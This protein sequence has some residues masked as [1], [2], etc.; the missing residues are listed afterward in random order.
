M[1]VPNRETQLF[2][3]DIKEEEEVE[4]VGV[5]ENAKEGAAVEWFAVFLFD[6][7]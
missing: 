5:V 7:K 4:D 3:I 6:A 1:A 2:E